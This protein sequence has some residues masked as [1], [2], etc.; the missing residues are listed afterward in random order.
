MS[1]EEKEALYLCMGS[2]CHQ[3]GVY[4]VLP[5]VEAWIERRCLQD[6][7]VLKGSFCLSP[8]TDGIAMKFRD[9]MITNV[10]ARNVDRKL[11]IEVLPEIRAGLPESQD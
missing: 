9:V 5:K 10:N 1:E 11:D 8:C 6:M 3:L 2:A 4:D 7:L